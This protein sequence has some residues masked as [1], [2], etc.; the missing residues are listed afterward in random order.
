MTTISAGKAQ[1]WKNIWP[2]KAENYTEEEREKM[3]WL[4]WKPDPGKPDERPW[5]QWMS[6]SN[7][8]VVK[9]GTW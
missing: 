5:R 8:T 1:P 4:G 2:L 6:R 9:R 3:P 7:T